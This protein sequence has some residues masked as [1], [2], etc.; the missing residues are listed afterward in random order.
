MAKPFVALLQPDRLARKRL[1]DERRTAAPLDAAIAAHAALLEAIAKALG[2]SILCRV[3]DDGVLVEGRGTL[4]FGATLAALGAFG[5]GLLTRAGGKIERGASDRRE[6]TAGAQLLR[7][8]WFP[9]DEACKGRVTRRGQRHPARYF[10]SASA[11]SAAAS[12]ANAASTWRVVAPLRVTHSSPNQ[13][14]HVTRTG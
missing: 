7:P 5:D 1:A 6:G 9:G 14:P 11:A 12:A 3:D 13:A 2:T 4:T 10:R 8:V